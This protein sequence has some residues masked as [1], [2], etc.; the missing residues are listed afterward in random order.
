MNKT[1]TGISRNENRDE[2]A[3]E[4]DNADTLPHYSY[5]HCFLSPCVTTYNRDAHWIGPGHPPAPE[6]ST[7]RRVICRKIWGCIA[8]LGAWQIPQYIQKKRNVGGGAAYVHHKRD[9]MPNCMVKLSRN[10]YLNPKNKEYMGHK[11]E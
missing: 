4:D 2:D 3:G 1:D 10:L 9:V 7:Q 6:N 5:P 11:W 8:N